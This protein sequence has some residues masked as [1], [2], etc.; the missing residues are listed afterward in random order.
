MLMLAIRGDKAFMQQ[1]LIPY[2]YLKFGVLYT[3]LRTLF[4]KQITNT[5]LWMQNHS[6]FSKK[7][8]VILK[9]HWFWNEDEKSILKYQWN[10]WRNTEK[11]VFQRQVGK[12][13]CTFSLICYYYTY[14]D[15]ISCLKNKQFCIKIS[16]GKK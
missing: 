15:C 2:S 1:C 16:G 12:W 9:K 4:C 3:S 14:R 11:A 6:F 7:P 13:K 8:F 5:T 10:F